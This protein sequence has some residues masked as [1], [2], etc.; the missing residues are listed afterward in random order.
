MD[1]LTNRSPAYLDRDVYFNYVTK[2]VLPDGYN[3]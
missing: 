1:R 3:L 2:G